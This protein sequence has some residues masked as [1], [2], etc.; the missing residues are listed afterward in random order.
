MC[1]FSLGCSKRLF[2]SVRKIIMVKNKY[3]KETE[4]IKTEKPELIDTIQTSG[5][6][7][8]STEKILT[9]II[10]NYNEFIFFLIHLLILKCSL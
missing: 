7:E 1:Y 9:E 2:K 8:E 10:E 5:K 4:K 6:L 3:T